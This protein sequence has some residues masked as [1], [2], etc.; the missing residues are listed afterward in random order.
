[1]TFKHR[2]HLKTVT[3]LIKLLLAVLCDMAQL[4]LIVQRAPEIPR[5]SDVFVSPDK[6]EMNYFESDESRIPRSL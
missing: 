2:L 1:M 3:F 4:R 5:L 6:D